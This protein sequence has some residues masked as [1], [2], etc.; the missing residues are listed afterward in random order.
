MMRGERVTVGKGKLAHLRY[1]DLFTYCGIGEVDNSR[2]T[3][4]L[5]LCKK[6]ELIR[7]KE[8]EYNKFAG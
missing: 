2:D 5:R 7:K 3:S 4:G 6:C 1:D 8:L